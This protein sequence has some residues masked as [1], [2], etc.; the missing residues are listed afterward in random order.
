MLDEVKNT[1]VNYAMKIVSHPM[2]TKIAS[3]PLLMKAVGKTFELHT[4]TCGRVKDTLHTV[5]DFLPESVS[6]YIRKDT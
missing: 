2:V 4:K 5:A 1:A 6:K 3:H